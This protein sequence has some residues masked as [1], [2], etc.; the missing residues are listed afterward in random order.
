MI[1]NA[2]RQYRLNYNRLLEEPKGTETKDP[3][4]KKIEKIVAEK[5]E[6]LMKTLEKR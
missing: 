6:A 5:F 2:V 4:E 1:R 3:L